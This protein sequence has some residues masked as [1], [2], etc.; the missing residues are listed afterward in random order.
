MKVILLQDISKIGKRGE[1]KEVANGYAINVLIAKGQALQAT[2]SEL[3]KWKAKADSVKHK[4]D[5]AVNAFLRLTD[6]LKKHTLII[7]DKKHDTKGQLFA[8]VKESDIADAIFAITK[9]SIDPKQVHIATVI[10]TVSKHSF[11]LKQGADE[12]L[13]VLEVQ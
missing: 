12:A 3:A 11:M 10:K 6:E 13:F 2:D 9:I 1:V 4:K 8:A 7:A 5:L